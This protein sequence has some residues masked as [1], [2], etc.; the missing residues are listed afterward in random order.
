MIKQNLNLIDDVYYSRE[1]ISLFLKNNDEI[2]DFEFKSG[3]NYFLNKTIK[4]PIKRIG[5]INVED[6]Y[7]DL[8]SAYGYGGFYTNSNDTKFI[9]NALEAYRDKCLEENII[10][11]FMRFHPINKFPINFN[12]Y[13]DFNVSNIY[14]EFTA[15]EIITITNFYKSKAGLK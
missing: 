4:R 3:D 8:E 10:A 11:E 6:G 12:E 13:L 15:Q 7:F 9:E 2:F 1:Y 14:Q 5:D